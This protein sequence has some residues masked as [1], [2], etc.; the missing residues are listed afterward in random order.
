MA[1][2][3][4]LPDLTDG[5]SSEGEDSWDRLDVSA[6]GPAVQ[7]DDYLTLERV[8]E[9]EAKVHTEWQRPFGK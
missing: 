3:G 4:V 8:K 9:F 2:R 1:I 6:D 5:H 7:E